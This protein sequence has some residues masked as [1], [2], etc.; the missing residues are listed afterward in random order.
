MPSFDPLGKKIK[1]LVEE[2]K[3]LAEDRQDEFSTI[4]TVVNVLKEW[5]EAHDITIVS[6]DTRG[7]SFEYDGNMMKLSVSIVNGEPYVILTG[8]FNIDIHDPEFKRLR[9]LLK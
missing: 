4:A 9:E 5:L 1:E 2:L 3:G 7:V 8:T 6:M